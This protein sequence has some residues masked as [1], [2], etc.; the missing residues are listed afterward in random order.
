M[1]LR[2]Q[3][4]VLH[5]QDGSQLHVQLNGLRIVSRSVR[6]I[7]TD[8]TERLRG[9]RQLPRSQECLPEPGEHREVSVK[10]D[11]LQATNA[12]RSE[13][14]VMLQPSEL[15]LDCGATSVQIASLGTRSGSRHGNMRPPK[16]SGRAG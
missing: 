14:V 5:Q 8:V 12:E 9:Y 2:P 3:R 13:A 16:A 4:V 6:R 15:A 10:R 1:I 11:L 7:G